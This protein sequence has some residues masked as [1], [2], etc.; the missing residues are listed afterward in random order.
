MLVPRTRALY[1]PPEG[2][3]VMTWC[4]ESISKFRNFEIEYL[5]AFAARFDFEIID[6]FEIITPLNTPREA[7]KYLTYGRWAST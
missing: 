6:V 1:F 4:F 2:G 3:T 5:R 7:G